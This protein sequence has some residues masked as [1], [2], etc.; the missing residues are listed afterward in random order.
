M[1]INKANLRGIFTGFRVTFM[2]AYQAHQEGILEKL[3]FRTTSTAAE[4]VYHW[5]GALPG[6]KE[7]IDEIRIENVKAHNYTVANREFEDTVAVK[8]ADIER[9]RL[10]IYTPLM[11][12]MGAVAAQHDGQELAALLV[13]GFSEKCY[14][15]KNFFDTNHEPIKGGTKF[16]NVLTKKLS[17]ANFRAERAKIKQRKNAAGRVMGLGRARAGIDQIHHVP[18]GIITI[19]RRARRNPTSRNS[20]T[21]QPTYA[22]GPFHAIT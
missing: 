17:Q 18:V 20:H 8:E 14:T 7:L 15:G 22:T 19:N 13:A 16:T 10:G 12:M 21:D 9:D 6:M 1:Q 2:E 4:E 11:G 3:A 5:L